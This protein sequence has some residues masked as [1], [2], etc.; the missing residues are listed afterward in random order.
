MPPQPPHLVDLAKA[1][2]VPAPPAASEELRRAWAA[3]GPVVVACVDPGPESAAHVAKTPLSPLHA[4]L[5]AVCAASPAAPHPPQPQHLYAL[6]RAQLH[7]HAR[8]AAA[9]F[10]DLLNVPR[11][12]GQA[13]FL[14]QNSCVEARIEFLREVANCASEAG[15]NVD[16]TNAANGD[17]GSGDARLLESYAQLWTAYESGING[18]AALFMYLD[19]VWVRSRSEFGAESLLE[20]ECLALGGCLAVYDTRTTALL[21]WRGQVIEPLGVHLS[22]SVL[23]VVARERRE[24][25]CYVCEDDSN[26]SHPPSVGERSSCPQSLALVLDSFCVVNANGLV[27]AAS[28]GGASYGLRDVSDGIPSTSVTGHSADA[29]FP[30]PLRVPSP[31]REAETLALYRRLFEAPFLSAAYTYYAGESRALLNKAHPISMRTYLRTVERLLSEELELVSGLKGYANESTAGPLRRVL[32]T[33]LIAD[34]A[35]AFRIEADAMFREDAFDDLRRLHMLLKRVS[36]ALHPYHAMLRAHVEATGVA[37]VRPWTSYD[38][39]MTPP[40]AELPPSWLPRLADVD[41]AAVVG[42]DVSST[43]GTP[44]EEQLRHA[45]PQTPAAGFVQAAWRVFARYSLLVAFAFG[46]DREFTNALEQG[47]ERFLNSVRAAPELLAEF[48]HNILEEAMPS[49]CEGDDVKA[50]PAPDVSADSAKEWMSRVTR[51]FRFLS[52]K[53]AFQRLYS[54]KLTRRLVY[55]TS[56]STDVEEAM[57]GL[58]RDTC[59]RDYTS[60]LQ[61]MF[62][63]IAAS[64]EVSSRFAD[65][66]RSGAVPAHDLADSDLQFDV[67][68]L[69]S[70]AWPVLSHSRIERQHG[71]DRAGVGEM[72]RSD[73]PGEAATAR[74]A[75]Q[76]TGGG[77]ASAVSIASADREGE[78][79]ASS[80]V[81]ADLGGLSQPSPPEWQRDTQTIGSLDPPQQQTANVA[82]SALAALP[83]RIA[84]VSA[85][86]AEFYSTSS[87]RFEDRRLQWM[88]HLSRVELAAQVDDPGPTPRRRTVLL[89]ASLPQAAVLLQ[90]NDHDNLSVQALCAILGLPAAAV[91]PVAAVLV[92][93][94]ILAAASGSSNPSGEVTSCTILSVA[95]G[96][97]WA[98]PDRTGRVPLALRA[99]DSEDGARVRGARASA[100][101]DRRQEVKACIVRLLK[102]AKSIAEAELI[103]RVRE[104]M[105]PWFMLRDGDV[106]ACIASLVENEYLEYQ[107]GFCVYVA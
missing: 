36:N 4:T 67:L 60:R 82:L 70:A 103:R 14:A 54:V 28:A 43:P 68:V 75:V 21:A 37:A 3:A 89:D 97:G 49:L 105:A 12:A 5:Y 71:H 100:D 98:L 51:M 6:V 88:Y 17:G 13:M 94:G 26:A 102:E 20:E 45:L 22:E 66:R 27:A 39:M 85:A 7:V 83:T 40:T 56:V 92:R 72:A 86:F 80:A 30:D 46:G 9:L 87:Q 29:A 15:P 96:L 33:A 73:P 52:D 11:P 16:G 1:C 78:A 64:A 62:A 18:V 24:R 42:A 99:Y 65:A 48:C 59:G 2:V 84:R 35:D 38:T 101:S 10:A 34:H 47:C 57:L 31:E 63:D 8:A 61:R 53:D 81:A 95:A 44:T 50:S 91:A 76:R 19:R 55:H 104:R 107:D 90:F 74:G 69:C 77:S 106:V 25:G 32:E 93:A 58:L 23:A 41:A 79:R